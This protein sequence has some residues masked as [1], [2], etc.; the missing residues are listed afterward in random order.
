MEVVIPNEI[1][2]PTTKTVV[3]SQRDENEELDR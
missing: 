1:G 2:M 3:Q